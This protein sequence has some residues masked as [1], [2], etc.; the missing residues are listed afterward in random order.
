MTEKGEAV[1]MSKWYIIQTRPRWEKKVADCL[2]RKGVESYC[3]LKKVKRKWSDRIKILE[4]PLLKSH[5]FVKILPEQK[6]DVRITEGV[7]N[8]AYQNGKPTQVKEKQIKALKKLELTSQAAELA[9]VNGSKES[10]T[11]NNKSYLEMLQVLIKQ[12]Q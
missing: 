1:R 11:E 3:P 9:G 5:V 6:I 10:Y 7:V 8:F 2:E 4:E 12:V